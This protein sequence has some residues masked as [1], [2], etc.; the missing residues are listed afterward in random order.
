MPAPAAPPASLTPEQKLA[1]LVEHLEPFFA[2]DGELKTIK[3]QVKA[4]VAMFD[5]SEKIDIKAVVEQVEKNKAG[6]ETLTKRIRATKRGGFDLEGAE[7]MPFS[8]HKTLLAV[9]R[10]NDRRYGG[11]HKQIFE[12]L[13]AGH[14]FEVLKM[15][16]RQ[17][18]N[19]GP[20]DHFRV[21]DEQSTTKAIQNISDDQLGGFFVPDQVAAD[22]IGPIYTRSVFVNA[23][24]EDGDTSRVSVLD[25]IMGGRYDTMRFDGGVVAF[26]LGEQEK[27]AESVAK[28]GKMSLSPKRL[29]CLVMLTEPMRKFGANGFEALLR[30]DMTRA[31][32]KKIDHAIAYGQGGDDEPRGIAK[33][34]LNTA[35]QVGIKV[36]KALVTSGVDLGDVVDPTTVTDWDAF[37]VGIETLDKMKL[38][39][40]ED[41]VDADETFTYVSSPRFFSQLKNLKVE[42]FSGSQEQKS[43]FVLGPPMITDSK[44]RDIIG[45]FGKSTQIPTTAKPGASIEGPTDST[46]DKCSD[47]FFGNLGEVL[48]GRWAGIEVTSDG[49]TGKYFDQGIEQ[50]KLVTYCDVGIRQARALGICPNAKVR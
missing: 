41:N 9:S 40:E 45:P 44:L 25:G 46:D 2:E 3:S 50:I 5:G 23:T 26:W 33:S 6:L 34:T 15:V 4:L 47:V 49:A 27:I 21:F 43:P 20:D 1:K 29:G 39:L 17:R 31:I 22:I 18:L 19:A 37:P 48:F 16:D 24:G 12:S 38:I 30:R 14:E 32:A 10:S 11:S 42:Q 28:M 8:M 13:G 7:G 36:F 35:T